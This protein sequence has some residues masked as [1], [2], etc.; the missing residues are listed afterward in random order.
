MDELDGWMD[1]QPRKEARSPFDG[2]ADGVRIPNPPLYTA[3]L[4]QITSGLTQIALGPGGSGK[5]LRMQSHFLFGEA[6]EDAVGQRP[7]P[8]TDSVRR[9]VQK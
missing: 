4:A 3:G 1:V 5:F 6:G 9:S 8:A 7:R 2:L